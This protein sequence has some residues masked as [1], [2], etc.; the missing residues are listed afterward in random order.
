[1]Q[2]R[3]SEPP[4]ALSLTSASSSSM[5]VVWSSSPCVP[6]WLSLPATC[7]RL[8]CA[9]CCITRR[10]GF[11]R[12]W[13]AVRACMPRAACRVCRTCRR[14]S[15]I[16]RAIRLSSRCCCSRRSHRSRRAASR[17]CLAS[18]SISASSCRSV[19]KA[20]RL[21]SSAASCESNVTRSSRSRARICS[22]VRRIDSASPCLSATFSRRFSSCRSARSSGS[23]CSSSDCTTRACCDSCRVS[24]W[25]SR[26]S[27]RRRVRSCTSS[28]WRRRRPCSCRNSFSI[29][30]ETG[31]RCV[32][33]RCGK[34]GGRGSLRVR[35]VHGNT[36]AGPARA[37]R[38]SPWPPRWLSSAL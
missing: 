23:C 11:S 5:R 30:F 28:S 2:G 17:P 21:V 33:W 37:P 9:I 27:D 10:R 38:P 36:A 19:R 29:S 34:G 14:F 8:S 25:R 7:A 16:P 15:I 24:L 22:Y 4:L 18:A 26:S 12:S 6:L 13:S 1:M 3:L 31:R 20:S 32:R 35:P